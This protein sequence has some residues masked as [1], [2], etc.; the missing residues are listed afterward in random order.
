V[1]SAVY[2]A[3]KAFGELPREASRSALASALFELSPHLR[4]TFD[5]GADGDE[6]L[7]WTSP[8]AV[9]L[10]RPAAAGGARARSRRRSAHRARDHLVDAAAD[11]IQDGNRATIR[12]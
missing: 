7:A 10:P 12:Q 5:V 2:F 11:A 9:V 6:A 4:S 3:A 8:D 1:A